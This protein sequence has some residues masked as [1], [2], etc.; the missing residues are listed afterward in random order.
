MDIE[1]IM[2]IASEPGPK[3]DEQLGLDIKQSQNDNYS[4]MNLQLLSEQMN[5]LSHSDDGCNER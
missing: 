5:F 1:D 3:T 2:R 4:N